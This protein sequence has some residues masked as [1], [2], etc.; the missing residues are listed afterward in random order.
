MAHASADTGNRSPWDR[1]SWLA[2]PSWLVSLL[3][4]GTFLGV[5]AFSIRQPGTTGPRTDENDRLVGIYTK[6]SHDA[7]PD[8][9]PQDA[10]PAESMASLP[11]DAAVPVL[12]SSAPEQLLDLPAITP[13]RIGPGPTFPVPLSTSSKQVVKPQPST[14]PLPTAAGGG[15]VSGIPFFDSAATG[16]RFAYVLDSSGSMASHNAIGVAKTELLASLQKLDSNQEFQIIFYNEHSYPMVRPGA[17]QSLFAATDI[18]RNQARQFVRS[19]EPEGGT[20]HLEA[21]NRALEL[22]PQPDVMFFLSDADTGLSAADLDRIRK[23][24]GGR[25]QIHTVEFGAGA[26]LAQSRSFLKRLADQNNG[27]YSYRDVT[28]FDR[29]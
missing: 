3:L 24:N 11:A 10:E 4:H 1:Y 21:L 9:L 28:R 29:R 20:N 17:R 8:D 5:L 12:D 19:V 16:K 18:N 2:V 13:P 15:A 6:K 22:K 7:L 26:N 27:T 14:R 23:K 25:T